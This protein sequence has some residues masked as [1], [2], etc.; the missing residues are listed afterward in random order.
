MLAA[1]AMIPALAA[2]SRMRPQLQATA[3]I[4]Q[5]A[6]AFVPLAPTRLADTRDATNVPGY[7]ELVRKQSIRV[8]VAGMGGAPATATAAVLNVTAVA[9]ACPSTL[10]SRRSAGI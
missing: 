6:T 10:A 3:V 9:L 2:M 1:G 5:G 8:P 7:T 4:T